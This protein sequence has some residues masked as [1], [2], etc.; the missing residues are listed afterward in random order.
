M[1]HQWLDTA[2]GDTFWTQRTSA[3]TGAAGS[4]VT[5]NDTAP[6][7]DRWNMSVVEVTSA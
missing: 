4:T 7:S 5:I 3:L 1:A 2:T 6:T